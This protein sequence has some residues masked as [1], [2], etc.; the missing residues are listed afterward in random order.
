LISGQAI[1]NYDLEVKAGMNLALVLNTIVFPLL[2]SNTD[3]TAVP[4]KA[5]GG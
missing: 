3:I 4:I 5:Y 2:K 1:P